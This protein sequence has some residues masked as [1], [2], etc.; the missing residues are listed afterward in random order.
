MKTVNVVIVAASVAG[1]AV[2]VGVVGVI[3]AGVMWLNYR[4]TNQQVQ[5]GNTFMR[6]AME[7]GNCELCRRPFAV[8]PGTPRSIVWRGCAY[9]G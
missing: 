2:L 1:L 7:G 9:Q 5:A 6:K 3:G 4:S 8:P